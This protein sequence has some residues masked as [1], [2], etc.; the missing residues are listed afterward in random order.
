MSDAQE[1]LNFKLVKPMRTAH[2]L[3]AEKNGLPMLRD[4]LMHQATAEIMRTRASRGSKCTRDQGEGEGSRTP[5]RRY[6]HADLSSEETLS[7]LYSISDN[8]GTRDST[9]TP[10]TA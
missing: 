1:L 5:S 8:N 6:S 4:G 10:W 7:V 3:L 9:A 2:A